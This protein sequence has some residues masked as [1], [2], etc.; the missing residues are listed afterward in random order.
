MSEIK[1]ISPLL[2]NFDIGGSI[3]DHNGVT[4]YP[5]MRK[6]TTDRYI[7]KN[8]SIPASQTK[9]DALLLTGAYPDQASALTYFKELA[10]STVEELETLQKLAQIEGFLSY[11]D[12]QV[13]VKEDAVGYD[14]CMLSTYKYSLRKFLQHQPITHLSAMNLGLDLCSALAACR[15]AGYIYVNLKPNNIYVTDDRNFKIGDLGFLRLDSLKYATLPEK[16]SSQYTAPEALDVLSTLTPTLDIYAVGLILYQAYNGGSLPFATE[17]AS[18]EKFEPPLFADY[19]MSEI[20]LKACDPDPAARWQDP[21]ELGH[22]LVSYMQRN[23]ANDTPIVPPIVE[24]PDDILEDNDL[25]V[26]EE[27]SAQETSDSL[28]DDISAEYTDNESVEGDSEGQQ[29]PADIDLSMIVNT[30]S[31]EQDIS[32]DIINLEDLSFLNDLPVD[33]T[34]PENNVT[35]I[36]YDEVSDE[37]SK[38]LL[39]ADELV[40]YPVPDASAAMETLSTEVVDE[41]DSADDQDQAPKTETE[42]PVESTPNAEQTE[43]PN[44]DSVEETIVLSSTTEES[45]EDDTQD[46]V[47]TDDGEEI[48][49]TSD[50]EEDEQ[51]EDYGSDRQQKRKRVI[52]WILTIVIFLLIA[53]ITAVAFFYY[54]NIYLLPID[55]IAVD[56]N[57]SSMVV[58]VDTEIDESMLTVI[59]SDSHGNQVSSPVVNGTASFA[60]L[61]PDTAYTVRILVDGFHRLT[62]ETAASYSTPAQTNIVQFSA[63]TGS[64]DGSVILSFN[65]EGPDTGEWKILYSADGEEEKSVDVLSHMVTLTG[66]TVG[67][68][69]TFTLVPGDGMY[70]TG[71]TQIKFTASNLIYA[72][73]V[74]ITSC[75]DNTLTVVW[76]A[77]EGIEV[78]SWTVRCYNDSEY[79]Q[80]AIT[81]DTEAVFENVDPAYSH[82]VEVT[83]AGM[84]VSERAYMSENAVTILSFAADT[85]ET[86]VLTLTWESSQPVP[87]DGWVILYSVD[88]SDSQA[89]VTATEN[90]VQIS[91]VVPGATY[92]FKIQQSNGVPVLSL[93]LTCEIPDAQD[94][95]GYGMTRGTMSF[96]LC[97]R[98][99]GEQWSWSN[100][101]DSDITSTFAVGERIGILGQLHGKYGVSKDIITAM[102]VIKDAEG[103][104]ICYSS[105]AETWDEMWELSYAEIDIPQIPAE[106]GEYT[107]TMYF[108][109]LYVTQKSFTIV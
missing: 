49:E 96:Q 55:N 20:I 21:T 73:N 13:S 63:V 109:G 28:I 105:A 19:E 47:D 30:N 99:D 31:T 101:S 89:S 95:S 62:G 10:D 35:D 41:A 5:A 106:P 25:G 33:D 34:S 3:S 8:V 60:N 77:P 50:F 51:D 36:N 103:H 52:G 67:K 91:P 86:N 43:A 93:P 104:L 100:L 6:D 59:C 57:E 16:Y 76:D 58:Q 37:L 107:V 75:V 78:P 9:L 44:A 66:L 38:I 79:N 23:G 26:Q 102:F 29:T 14:V 11:E 74:T 45:S 40:A 39:Q 90:S 82:T 85:S 48:P 92:S 2:D 87:A 72:K 18:A 108:N 70:V 80:T 71:L 56:G 68:E 54:K 61:T 12:W 94:F 81:S 1:L 53:A 83:A 64:D 27:L 97:K 65:L 17:Y 84:S 69:Y 22:A 24:L 88:G 32:S 46:S 4:C 42:Q 7:I 15:R 98:P